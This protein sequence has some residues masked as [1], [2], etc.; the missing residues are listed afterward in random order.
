MRIRITK[1][2][3]APLMDGFD[4]ARFQFGRTYHVNARLGRYLILAGYGE[5][6]APERSDDRARR[7]KQSE[8]DE[9]DIPAE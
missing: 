8:R 5:L 3:P 1:P 4:V 7:G 2:P 9:D 6:A